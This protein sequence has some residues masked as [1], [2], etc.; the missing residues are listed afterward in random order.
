MS[1]ENEHSESPGEPL[2]ELE[3]SLRALRPA[4][5]LDRD[6]TLFR[7]GQTARHPQPRWRLAWPALAA[8]FALV[9]VGQGVLLARRPTEVQIVYVNVPAPPTPPKDQLPTAVAQS[10]SPRRHWLDEPGPTRTDRLSWQLIRYGLDAL[11]ATPVAAVVPR[12]PLN[13]GPRDED[14]I[15][16][17]LNPG[18]PS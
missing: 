5:R 17:I 15:R 4:S 16:K 2:S 11:P 1:H 10:D 7:A 6:R 9:I 14:G 18:G 12:E 13:A 3:Q 8:T